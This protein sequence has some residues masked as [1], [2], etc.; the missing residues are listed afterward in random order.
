MGVWLELNARDSLALSCGMVECFPLFDRV[1]EVSAFG[2][3]VVFVEEFEIVL[4]DI[5]RF[6]RLECF[7][8]E[9]V[10]VV[11][12]FKELLV[13]VLD[14]DFA[15]LVFELE[16]FVDLAIP[17]GLRGRIHDRVAALQSDIDDFVLHV[18]ERVALLL[19]FEHLFARVGLVELAGLSEFSS[20]L[21]ELH[22]YRRTVF[23]DRGQLDFFYRVFEGLLPLAPVPHALDFVF[24]LAFY[25]NSF[26]RW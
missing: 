19:D 24:I 20:L 11:K 10:D 6:V 23:L 2:G 7:L 22:L 25:V 9:R 21:N 13:V 4:V 15:V 1:G 18:R 12:E 3:G 17:D 8:D 5:D 26:S 14:F 16:R